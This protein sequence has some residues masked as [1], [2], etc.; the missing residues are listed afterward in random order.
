MLVPSDWHEVQIFNFQWWTATILRIEKLLKYILYMYMYNVHN[1]SLDNFGNKTAK[2]CSLSIVLTA[3][4]QK[5]QK[6][7]KR[8]YY[9]ASR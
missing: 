3:T 2:N 7:L 5:P 6:S 4:D 1:D 9:S 8:S